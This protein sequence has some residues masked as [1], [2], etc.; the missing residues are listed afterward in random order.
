MSSDLKQRI[1]SAFDPANLDRAP[2]FPAPSRQLFGRGQASASFLFATPF[3]PLAL[4]RQLIDRRV[5]P[6]TRDEIRLGL[7][8]GADHVPR[9]VLAVGGDANRP[10][11][12]GG[13]H[14]VDHPRRD[15]LPRQ[16]R[17][18]TVAVL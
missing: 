5:R 7:R 12:Q 13:A 16:K 8:R 1:Y 15:L 11:G 10:A 14:V 2:T 4:R 3:E 18:R 9:G 17:M 6:Q